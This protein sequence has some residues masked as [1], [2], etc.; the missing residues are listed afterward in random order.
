M[1]KYDGIIF[2]LDGTMWDATY[3]L[4]DSWNQAYESRKLPAR[5]PITRE[6]LKACMGLLIPDIAAKLY[7]ECDEQTQ[8]AIM[9]AAEAFEETMLLERGGILYP[10]LK[11]TLGK[12]KEKG[13]L[14]FVVSNCQSG[15]IETFIKAHHLEGYFKDFECPGNTGL[16]KAENIRLITKR[17]ALCA[18]V[19]VGDTNT[20]ALA[21]HAAGVPFIF[22]A[23]GFG[24]VDDCEGRIESFEE[25]A[26]LVEMDF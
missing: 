23:Y 18:P 21:A 11:E 22:A 3:V 19:Y 6:D 15:Y 1:K 2:D 10:G 14:L 9:R 17:N 13:Y 20:D 25:L 7:P 16:K 26:D 12:L 4:V 5:R 24:E 8:L